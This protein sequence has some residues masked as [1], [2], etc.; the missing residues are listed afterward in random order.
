MNKYVALFRGINVSGTNSMPMSELRRL[1]ESLGA[2]SVRTYLQSGNAV[3]TH[4]DRNR[5]QLRDAIQSA[6][7]SAFGFESHLVLLSSKDLHEAIDGNP[8]AKESEDPKS[9]HLCV[10]AETPTTP[11]LTALERLKSATERS[12]LRGRYFYLHAPDGV[13]RSRLAKGY[14]KALGVAATARNWRTVS[15]LAELLR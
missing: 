10:L 5:T 3:F 11:D 13:G 7:A 12:L 4:G 1:L 15:A 6:A 8:F 9:V 2:Q 14:E